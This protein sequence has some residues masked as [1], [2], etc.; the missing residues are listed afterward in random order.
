MAHDVHDS[1]NDLEAPKGAT[2]VLVKT[3][4]SPD[5][6]YI[7][8]E[9]HL[10]ELGY[11]LKT[12]NEAEKVIVTAYQEQKSDSFFVQYD[13][14]SITAAVVDA[15]GGAIIRL[16]G[17]YM[18]RRESIVLSSGSGT[19]VDPEAV[20][21]V[22]KGFESSSP[23]ATFKEMLRVAESYPGKTAIAFE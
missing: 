9:K 12:N 21:A 23:K 8:I 1:H 13:P 4:Q 11:Q 15:D 17:T 18:N 6:A 3:G 5:D 19:D 10:I 22:Y 14:S 7:G 20:M 16:T 2:V